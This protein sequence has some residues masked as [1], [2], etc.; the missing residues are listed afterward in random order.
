MK[1]FTRWMVLGAV[2][3]AMALTGCQS[4]DRS[5]ESMGGGTGGSGSTQGTQGT[6]GTEPGMG[7]GHEQSPSQGEGSTMDQG[8]GGAGYDAGTGGS[9]YDSGTGGS[10]YDSGT[11]GSGMEPGSGMEGSGGSNDTTGGN[12]GSGS[13]PEPTR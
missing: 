11:G 8:T 2:A 3:G 4:K 6:Q 7:T 12:T 13:V 5:Q 10:G 9:G 1:G